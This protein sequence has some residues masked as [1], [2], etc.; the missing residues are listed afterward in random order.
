M[1]AK[2]RDL[3]VGSG[4]ADILMPHSKFVKEHKNLLGVLKRGKR[5]ELDAEYADQAKELQAH[6]GTRNSG[7]IA[8]MMGEVKAVHKGAYKPITALAKGSKMNAPV[9]WDYNKMPHHLVRDVKGVQQKSPSSWLQT[10]FG[11][12]KASAPA[13]APEPAVKKPDMALLGQYH[14]ARK[15]G[16]N[17]PAIAQFEKLYHDWLLENDKE[18]REKYNMS[19][20]A[21]EN[22]ARRD[23]EY[24]EERYIRPYRKTIANIKYYSQ[25]ENWKNLTTKERA[26]MY[27]QIHDLDYI[28]KQVPE[29]GANPYPNADS[30][31]YVEMRRAY[32]MWLKKNNLKG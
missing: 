6:G 11:K 8:R 30:L 19:D 1:E 32:K 14:N 2:L 12:A 17:K 15:T 16:K 29:V 5:S 4:M 26:S 27:Q 31:P 10:K 18:Y 28:Q 9:V 13:K 7:F 22:K 24:T 23:R 3:L 20:V 25:P 21:K